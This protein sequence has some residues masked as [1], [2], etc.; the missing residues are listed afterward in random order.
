[1]LGWLLNLGFA[2]SGVTIPAVAFT[3]PARGDDYT[4]SAR[5][6]DYTLPSRAATWTLPERGE[7]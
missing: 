1:M 2:G 7:I 5:R 6:S 4:L 3:L